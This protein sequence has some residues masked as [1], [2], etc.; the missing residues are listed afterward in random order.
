[1]QNLP[2]FLFTWNDVRQLREKQAKKI[3]HQLAIITVADR[4]EKPEYMDALI[5]KGTQWM[6]WSERISAE[7]E[8]KL[9]AA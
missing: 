3:V 6:L 2:N 1:M 7:S 9:R 5:R 4:S 8:R